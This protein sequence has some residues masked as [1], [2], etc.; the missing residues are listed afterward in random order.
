MLLFPLLMF[1]DPEYADPNI[2]ETEYSIVFLPYL[3][4]C[5]VLVCSGFPIYPEFFVHPLVRMPY[6][7]M[8]P[9]EYSNYPY[10]V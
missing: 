3:T 5:H 8:R 6:T 7:E 1:F 4:N 2:D 9:C 10:S